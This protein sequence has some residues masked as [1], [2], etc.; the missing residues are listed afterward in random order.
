M[1]PTKNK[2]EL[3]NLAKEQW[4]ID[5]K[6]ETELKLKTLKNTTMNTT[7]KKKIPFIEDKD[8]D[9]DEDKDKD[10]D[11]DEDEIYLQFSKFLN[12][13]PNTQRMNLYNLKNEK[14]AQEAFTILY[15]N[16]PFDSEDESSNIFFTQKW[17][18]NSFQDINEEDSILF[19]KLITLLFSKPSRHIKFNISD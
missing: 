12:T 18:N 3:K 11:E 7:K 2:L 4:K 6:T 5:K 16:M 15:A 9:E 17:W 10:E 1:Y 14:G 19:N 8:E 13:L